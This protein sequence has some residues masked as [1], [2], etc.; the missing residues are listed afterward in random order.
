[1]PCRPHTLVEPI[2]NQSFACRNNDLLHAEITPHHSL[3]LQTH[4]ASCSPFRTP[5]S[6][7]FLQMTARHHRHGDCP[8]PAHDPDIFATLG[9]LSADGRGAFRDVLRST[10][11]RA[12]H[13]AGIALRFVM[14]SSPGTDMLWEEAYR[15]GD[16]LLI[17]TNVSLPRSVGPLTSLLGW[18]R[19][20]VVAWPRAELI[21]KADD[22][23]WVDLRGVS[24]QLN[25]T[26]A[27]IDDHAMDRS[28]AGSSSYTVTSNADSSDGRH[29]THRKLRTHSS[30][31]S[32]RPK[33]YWGVMETFHWCSGPHH[34]RRH[35]AFPRA[36]LFPPAAPASYYV[37]TRISSTRA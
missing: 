25:A 22:D 11:F 1:M 31:A 16:V 15:H 8:A 29:E 35:F 30:S 12:S 23:V 4:A 2:G 27:A 9:V 10:W 36:P 34:H 13:G 20:A 37:I 33:L 6:T 7:Q 3:L 17:E 19:C 26:L 24:W 5:S 28:G 21:G 32:S 18:W 14:R